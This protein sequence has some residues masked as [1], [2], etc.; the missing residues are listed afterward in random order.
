MNFSEEKLTEFETSLVKF[1]VEPIS[2][3]QYNS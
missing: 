3:E 1:Q 2:I